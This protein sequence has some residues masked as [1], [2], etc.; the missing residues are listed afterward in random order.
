MHFI[1]S[2]AC[3]TATFLV[4]GINAQLID[5]FSDRDLD[6]NPA[7]TGNVGAY[8]VNGMGQLQLNATGASS[9][10]LASALQLSS[11]DNVEW[12]FSV[13]QNYA[14]SNS[15]FCKI[16]LVANTEFLNATSINGYYLRLGRDLAADVVDFYRQNGTIN[17]SLAGT[18]TNIALAHNVEI[19]V[20]RSD[21]GAWSIF[22][23]TVTNSN[24]GAPQAVFTD[25]TYVQSAYFGIQNIVTSSNS[26]NFYLDNVYIHTPFDT[27]MPSIVGY[28]LQNDNTIMVQFDEYLKLPI[29]GKYGDFEL[30]NNS[31]LSNSLS[32]TTLTLQFQ[33]PFKT[34]NSLSISGV[35]DFSGNSMPIITLDFIST[36]VSAPNTGIGNLLDY[37]DITINELMADINPVPVGLPAVEYIE[38]F[39]NTS[40]IINL[41]GDTLIDGATKRPFTRSFTLAGGSFGLI[42]S[43]EGGKSQLLSQFPT[44]N[45]YTLSGFGL[46]DGGESLTLKDRTGKLIDFVSYKT[47]WYKDSDKN[48]GGFA[49][50]QINPKNP[51]SGAA[52]WKV[53][54]DEKGGSPGY[55]NTVYSLENEAPQIKSVV[56]KSAFQLEVIFN[57]PMDTVTFKAASYTIEN[58]LTAYLPVPYNY[59]Q[60]T[61]KL[62]TSQNLAVGKAYQ[63]TITGIKN[64]QGLPI[65]NNIFTIGLPRLPNLGEIILNEVM[66]EPEP[67]VQLPMAEFIELYNTTNDLLDVSHFTVKDAS[68]TSN[69]K[70]AANA[71]VR[72]KNYLILASESSANY[73]KEFGDVAIVSNFPSLNKTGDHISITDLN[74]VIVNQII[75]KPDWYQSEIKAEGGWTLERINPAQN[76]GGKHNWSSSVDVKGGTPGKANSI[77]NTL[78]DATKPL[79]SNILV[80]SNQQ[81]SLAFSEGLKPDNLQ[82]AFSIAGIG[83]AS[84]TLSAQNSDTVFVKLAQP[85]DSGKVLS[86]RIKNLYD[87]S[88]NKIDYST[89]NIGIGRKPKPFEVV[90]NEIMAD[91][92]P[93]QSLPEA[94]FVELYNTTKDVLD[95]SNF[96]LF[97]ATTIPGKF[98]SSVVIEPFSYLIICGTSRVNDFKS[99]GNTVGITSFP[100]LNSSGDIV[101]LRNSLGT[102]ISKIKYSDT[103]YRDEIKKDGGWSLE[104]IDPLNPCGTANNWLA[105]ANE[106]FG[107]TPGKINSNFAAN[108]DNEAPKLSSAFATNTDSLWL[109]FNEPIDSLSSASA[110]A[111]ISSGVNATIASIQTDRILL[112]LNPSLSPSQQY[113]VAI[114]Q[115][116]DCVGNVIDGTISTPFYLTE[117]ADS[118]DV[119]INEILFN[120]RT[121]GSDFVEVYNRSSKYINLKNW[122][123]ANIDKG[124]IANFKPITIENSLLLPKS[125]RIFTDNEANIKN[126]YPNAIDSNFLQVRSLP[127]YNDGEGTVVLTNHFKKT[128]DLFNYKD[129]FHLKLIDNKEGISLERVNFNL[130]TNTPE[131]WASASQNSKFATPG[132]KNSQQSNFEISD[133]TVDIS[134]Q[135]FSP[136]QDGYLDFTTITF[137]AA[138]SDY[139]ANITIFDLEGSIVKRLVKNQN[140]GNQ[141]FFQW[142]GLDDTGRKTRVG[143]YM[144]YIEIFNLQGEI[145]SYKEN[146]VV[147]AKF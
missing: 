93:A 94:E 90:I 95:L 32:N 80:I 5:D 133:K 112:L 27:V 121:G 23:K 130:A 7:W 102:S 15:N 118:F 117:K 36:V 89:Q 8:T 57:Q 70:I 132:Y 142:D 16:Y 129:D 11:L 18:S 99:Y 123:L 146:V 17:T 9:S 64:C 113:L 52:N 31:L 76:C 26:K 46:T 101:D 87:C 65:A 40:K 28:N 125:Y 85:L 44:L 58:G 6:S 2:I 39:N 45:V 110:T 14:P 126:N 127:A 60:D 1:K 131:N 21:A 50:E 68:V 20:K 140:I 128:I 97:D 38:I 25:N 81:L 77:F 141:N 55:Q 56:S 29:L 136:D 86:L 30:Q 82:S 115:L 69:G 92:N 135:V 10:F 143:S 37:R 84:A 104:R 83:I 42:V 103:W 43:S 19:K 54:V 35:A 74:T 59:K 111:N 71:I 13:R 147:A 33:N 120:P 137:N 139:V 79:L 48:D 62:F 107:G 24:F 72:P 49:L 22:V 61:L 138:S 34:N 116:K 66:A 4:L 105:A 67:Q 145:K 63:F 41:M 106:S 96:R 108:P 109:Y 134:P 75:Y 122:Q 88:G 3:L 124:V 144:V 78:P 51:C 91:E 53:S 114:S 98:P 100:S 119:V 73:F 47:A 12:N